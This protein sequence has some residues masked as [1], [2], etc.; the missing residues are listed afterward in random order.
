LTSNATIDFKKPLDSGFF[1]WYL[2]IKEK[3]MYKVYVYRNEPYEF[4]ETF[5][6]KAESYLIALIDSAKVVKEKYKNARVAKVEP[7]YK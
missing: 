6:I 5:T 4:I 1:I 3:K 7:I 2:Y